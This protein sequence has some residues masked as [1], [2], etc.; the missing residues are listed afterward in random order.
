MPIFSN[1]REY[2]PSFSIFTDK[3]ISYKQAVSLV[4]YCRLLHKVLQ[5]PRYY[6]NY[7]HKWL[8]YLIKDLK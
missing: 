8:I 6:N 7:L 1:N 2:N 5:F 3:K 4:H